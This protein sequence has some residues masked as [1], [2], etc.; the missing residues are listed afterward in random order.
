MNDDNLKKSD[1]IKKSTE[2]SQKINNY[3]KFLKQDILKKK[4]E[5]NHIKYNYLT[6][7]VVRSIEKNLNDCQMIAFKSKDELQIEEYFKHDQSNDE[8]AL[9]N[10]LIDNIQ[11]KNSMFIETLNP[12]DQINVYMVFSNK[13]EKNINNHL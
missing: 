5:E 7:Q 10:D 9:S 13:L 2:E 3:I 6:F 12:N 1:V 8:E 4:N 11:K